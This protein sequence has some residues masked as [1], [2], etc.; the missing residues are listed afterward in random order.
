MFLQTNGPF[1]NI[2][3]LRYL[4]II[5]TLN[6]GLCCLKDTLQLLSHIVSKASSHSEFVFDLGL[7]TVSE[8]LHP[9]QY[10]LDSSNIQ[11]KWTPFS[12]GFYYCVYYGDGELFVPFAEVG[13]FEHLVYKNRP[14]SKVGKPIVAVG[15]RLSIDKLLRAIQRS[16]E[17][18]SLHNNVGAVDVAIVLETA[19]KPIS[20]SKPPLP[21]HLSMLLHTLR[22]SGYRVSHNFRQLLRDKDSTSNEA[23][24]PTTLCEKLFIPYLVKLSPGDKF[25]VKYCYRLLLFV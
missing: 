18:P 23:V 20:E 1:T 6:D 10:P 9:R 7:S 8:K 4:P 17:S 16:S 11:Q 14:P 3:L 25:E 2:C 5:K 15:M 13:H 19:T 24:D 22:A 12:A 21:V